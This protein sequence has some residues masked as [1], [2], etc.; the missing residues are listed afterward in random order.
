MNDF[1]IYG[2]SAATIIFNYMQVDVFLKIMLT[3]VVILYTLTKW[4][5]L[6]KEK[7]SF[8]KLSFL[9]DNIK[10]CYLLF[11]LGVKEI[12]G[13]SKFGLIKYIFIRGL[14]ISFVVGIIL[15]ILKLTIW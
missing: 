9:K 5:Y 14:I 6:L 4:Y 1:K 13:K 7:K 8:E 12:K 10:V 11:C 3:S 2:L 15:T